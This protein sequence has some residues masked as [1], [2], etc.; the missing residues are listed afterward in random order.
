MAPDSNT[1]KGYY[2]WSS[3]VYFELATSGWGKVNK[4]GDWLIELADWMIDTHR[5]LKRSR[6]TSSVCSPS[7]A[8]QDAAVVSLC[9]NL[10]GIFWIRKSPS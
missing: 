6:N 1:T 8:T 9:W 2:Q 5:T 3:M 10:A 7:L 4:Y